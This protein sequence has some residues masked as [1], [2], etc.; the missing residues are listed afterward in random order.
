MWPPT[1]S[2]Y[3]FS[4]AGKFFQTFSDVFLLIRDCTFHLTALGTAMFNAIM[5]FDW[6]KQMKD[7]LKERM[8]EM[9][10][11]MSD[12]QTGV[13]NYFQGKRRHRL[14]LRNQEQREGKIDHIKSGKTIPVMERQVH[15]YAVLCM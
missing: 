5:N 12:L 13:R 11:S 14:H 6:A 4:H 10:K 1:S 7:T 8:E 3:Q 2:L 15:V 9:D